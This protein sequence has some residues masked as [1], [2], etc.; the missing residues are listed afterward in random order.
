MLRLS[1]LKCVCVKNGRFSSTNNCDE[2]K[3]ELSA[4]ARSGDMHLLN[5]EILLCK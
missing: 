4:I 3:S 5:K 1:P 2:S